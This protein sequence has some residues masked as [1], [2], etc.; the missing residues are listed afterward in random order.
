MASVDI[1]PTSFEVPRDILKLL[2]KAKSRSYCFYSN[3]PVACVIEVEDE[4]G[5][6]IALIPGCNVENA[7]YPLC[8]CAERSVSFVIFLSLVM[9]QSLKRYI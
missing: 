2:E 5:R 4:N 1:T 7:S 8:I 9:Y 6:V 3:F